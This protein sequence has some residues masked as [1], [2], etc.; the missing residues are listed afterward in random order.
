MHAH[1]SSKKEE[2]I[3]RKRSFRHILCDAIASSSS[4]CFLIQAKMKSERNANT[5][6]NS[7]DIA[8][9]GKSTRNGVYVYSTGTEYA[10]ASS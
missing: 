2:Y 8:R 7:I 10:Y 9:K 4:L 6:N 3:E 5:I 1:T